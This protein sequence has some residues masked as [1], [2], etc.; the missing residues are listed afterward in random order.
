MKLKEIIANYRY[1][2][3]DLHEINFL[4]ESDE[5]INLFCHWLSSADLII[6]RFR[7]HKDVESKGFDLSLLKQETIVNIFTAIAANPTIEELDLSRCN[8]GGIRNPD[9]L[10]AIFKTLGTKEFTSLS[11]AKNG[12]SVTSM[13]QLTKWA[14]V[15]T[16]K[17]YLSGSF[18]ASIGAE[19]LWEL[20]TVVNSNERLEEFYLNSCELSRALYPEHIIDNDTYPNLSTQEIEELRSD[21]QA[22]MEELWAGFIS[23]TTLNRLDISWN[24]FP[25]W[26]DDEMLKIRDEHNR[27]LQLIVDPNQY[28]MPLVPAAAADRFSTGSSSTQQASSIIASD[29]DSGTVAATMLFSRMAT[30]FA[31]GT[32]RAM[33]QDDFVSEHVLTKPSSP[34]VH[35]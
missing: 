16:K 19:E 32:G 12:L 5:D 11:V 31:E 20:L 14:A 2:D 24:G 30:E 35:G 17:L 33:D 22:K 26:F 9:L 23:V 28:V 21:A 1:R 7:N 18:L 34:R 3:L 13:M 10:E 8:L 6:V 25:D 4:T 29:T 27:S 15:K